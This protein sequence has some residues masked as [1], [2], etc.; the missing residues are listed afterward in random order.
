MDPV[1]VMRQGVRAE[2]K[3]WRPPSMELVKINFNGV[4]FANENKFGIGV[5]I[6]NNEGLVLVSYAKK[7]PVA[8]SG[9][10]IE[11]MAVAA[12]LSFASD[13]SIK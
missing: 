13:I 2:E 12:A 4:A 6:R 7:I 11:T 9:C 5:V 1:E 8:Y 10:E 3:R